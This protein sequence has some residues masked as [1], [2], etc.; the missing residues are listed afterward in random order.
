MAWAASPAAG[1]ASA[2][3]RTRSA[4]TGK[5]RVPRA[6]ARVPRAQAPGRPHAERTGCV[7]PDALSCV[8]LQ[9]ELISAEFCH[10]IALCYAPGL[11]GLGSGRLAGSESNTAV[12]EG[13]HPTID[14]SS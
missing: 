1:H 3:S 12:Q 7:N 14:D 6:Q 13:M 5:P 2:L 9:R 11:S 10:R 4:G 8:I